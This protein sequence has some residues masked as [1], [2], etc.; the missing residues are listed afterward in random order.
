MA[1]PARRVVAVCGDGGF[2][3]TLQELATAVHHKISVVIVILDNSSFGNV[4]TIQ[5]ASY[6]ARHIAVDLTNPDFVA[7]GESFGIRSCRVESA[8]LF[9]VELTQALAADAPRLIVVPIGTVPSIWDLIRRP[10]SQGVAA[11]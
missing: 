11:H 7:L 4:K 6:G 2:M 10:P 9:E 5:A 8:E 1:D 3:F